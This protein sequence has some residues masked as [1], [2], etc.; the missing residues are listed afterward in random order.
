MPAETQLCIWSKFALKT[1]HFSDMEVDK[2]KVIRL[3]KEK[4]GADFVNQLEFVLDAYSIVNPD[5]E[6]IKQDFGSKGVEL[7]RILLS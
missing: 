6:I 7:A 1:P 3:A 5:N 4:Y 2:D